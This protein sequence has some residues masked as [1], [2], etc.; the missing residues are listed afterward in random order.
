M[1]ISFQY[2]G[3]QDSATGFRLQAKRITGAHLPD[4]RARVRAS[5]KALH[6]DQILPQF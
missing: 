4:D 2:T 6:R 1:R 3:G 5:E